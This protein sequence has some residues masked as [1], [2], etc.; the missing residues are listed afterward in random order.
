MGPLL[1]N[2]GS[3]E[4]A[5]RSHRQLSLVK[6]NINRYPAPGVGPVEY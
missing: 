6:I 4:H 2:S 1:G 5:Q 3:A